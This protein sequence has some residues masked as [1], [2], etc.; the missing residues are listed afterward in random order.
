M[1]EPIRDPKTNAWTY[2]PEWTE[3]QRA[4]YEA[5]TGALIHEQR[6]GER[7]AKAGEALLSSPEMTLAKMRIKVDEA[8]HDREV[9]ERRMKGEAAWLIER[10]RLGASVRRL[11]SREGDVIIQAA[12]TAAEAEEA[13][14]SAA[15]L[16]EA[17]IASAKPGASEAEQLAAKARGLREYAARQHDRIF[18]KCAV[19]GLD[20]AGSR[21]RLKMLVERY[22]DI[23]PH[24]RRLRDEMLN[25]AAVAEEKDFAP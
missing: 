24:L 19:G 23:L 25:G 21:A 5:I 12:M 8:K 7:I 16:L 22:A 14:E 9:S 6:E 4:H 17:A 20:A 18:D 1:S 2:P 10:Q 13:N 11:D 15:R 3:I